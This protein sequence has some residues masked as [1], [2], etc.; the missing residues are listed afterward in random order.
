VPF[1][2]SG[3]LLHNQAHLIPGEYEVE[4]AVKS[5]NGRGDRARFRINSPVSWNDLDMERL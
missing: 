4:I 1:A 5:E 3:S 2:L